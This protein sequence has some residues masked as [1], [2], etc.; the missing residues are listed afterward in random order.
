MVKDDTSATLTEP[1]TFN[2]SP[3]LLQLAKEVA[4]Y[5]DRGLSYVCRAALAEYVERMG[6]NKAAPKGEK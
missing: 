4:Q 6:A 2:V 5:T 1:I 3:A